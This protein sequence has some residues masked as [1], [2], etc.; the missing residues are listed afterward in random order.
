MKEVMGGAWM[1]KNFDLWFKPMMI[2]PDGSYG[3]FLE[4]FSLSLTNF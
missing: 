4:T 3:P 1:M 2:N